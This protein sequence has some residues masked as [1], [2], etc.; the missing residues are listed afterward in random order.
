M[1][2]KEI[3]DKVVDIARE[4][5]SFIKQTRVDGELSV[6]A[7]GHNDFVTRVD[8]LSEQRIVKAL[9][10]VLPE[11][12]FIVEENSVTGRSEEYNWI[13][14]PIDGTTNF[15]HGVAPYA[16]SIAL[17]L[18][19][20]IVLGVIYEA[21]LDEC[22]DAYKGGGAR[23]NGKE[24]RVSEVSSVEDSLIATG[25]PYSNYKYIDP[26]MD[27]LY[28]FMEHSH[29]LRR[30]GSAATDLA[31]VACGR[32]EA[33]YEYGLKPWDVAA[34]VVIIKE[35]GGTVSDFRGGND[36]LFGGEI[37]AAGK[38]VFSEMKDVINRIMVKKDK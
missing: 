6:E 26:F 24:I 25:F 14:D 38:N 8:K 5:G 19:D 33:F 4:T 29:G 37:I 20:E 22:F 35:A 28:Y 34:G 18:K 36:F 7:K 31:Y 17:S 12:G 9:K 10:E 30:L 23:L 13:V 1:D 27:S 16:V 21:G 3:C 32:F 2:L 11:A 15:I